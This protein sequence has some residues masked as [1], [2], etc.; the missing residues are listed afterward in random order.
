MGM[1][2]HH[3]PVRFRLCPPSPNEATTTLWIVT[4]SVCIS[5]MGAFKTLENLFAMIRLDRSQALYRT[6]A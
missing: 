1:C 3:P 6:R 2:G 5:M 4:L